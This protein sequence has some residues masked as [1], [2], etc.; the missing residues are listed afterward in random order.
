MFHAQIV[1]GYWVRGVE[2]GAEIK[3]R[4]SC[5][6]IISQKPL[7]WLQVLWKSPVMEK[8]EILEISCGRKPVLSTM[9]L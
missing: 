9:D 1:L 6:I 7:I 3:E 4:Y 8:A 5:I 2:S